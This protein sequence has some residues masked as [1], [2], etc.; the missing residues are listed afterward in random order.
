MAY[1]LVAKHVVG[2]YQIGDHI[3][4]PALV[5]KYSKSHPAHFTRKHLEE[6]PPSVT[7]TEPATSQTAAPV[8]LL[9]P[10]S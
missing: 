10:I 6:T 5:A 3:T 7:S 8:P 9:N 4:D 1:Q 2:K